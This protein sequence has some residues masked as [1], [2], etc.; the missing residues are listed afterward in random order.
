MKLK[1][2]RI[3]SICLI[4]AVSLEFTSCKQN[5]KA[6]KIS[7]VLKCNFAQEPE[8]IDPALNSSLVGKNVVLNTFEGLTTL[9][10]KGKIEGGAAE[11]WNVSGNGSNYTFFIR[12]D[13]KWSDGKPVTAQDFE[14]AWKRVLNPATNS[15]KAYKLYCIKNAEA[16]N[17]GKAPSGEVGI[18]VIDDYILNVVLEK[19]TPYFL[20]LAASDT[21]VPVRSDIIEKKGANWAS[22]PEMYIGNGPFELQKWDKKKSML[23]I[24]NKNYINSKKIKLGKVEITFENKEEVYSGNFNQGKIDVMYV[25][26]DAEV[27]TLMSKNEA[28]AYNNSGIYYLVFNLKGNSESS[29][30]SKATSN[31]KVRKA[32][33]MAMN[34]NI[35]ANNILN[36]NSKPAVGI[37]SSQVKDSSGGVFRDVFYSAG[38]NLDKAKGLLQEAGYGDGA[39]LPKLKIIYAKSSEN[40]AV[41]EAVKDML[42]RNLNLNLEE[43]AYEMQNLNTELRKRNYDMTLSEIQADYSDAA[44]FLEPWTSGSG[45]NIASYN[46]RAYDKTLD[47][48]EREKSEKARE[49]KIKN[50]EGI[51]MEDMPVV[52][53]V[54]TKSVVCSKKNVHGIY[55]NNYGVI[56]LKNAN[57][58]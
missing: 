41:V 54:E 52:P 53:L 1:F 34:R 22:T 31:S 39:K 45:E 16:Y 5:T 48:G 25:S 30:A 26:P 37:I 44:A 57:L 15:K 55:V 49:D 51:I 19:P 23:L 24:K 21:F 7:Q 2:Y 38:G 11:K 17:K 28:K 27:E 36:G 4:I 9:N 50:A 13:A 6:E 20:T 18:K 47:E 14:Y 29:E 46:N 35:I 56:Y 33:A 10:S 40:S 43:S 58:A 8:T 12:K 3:V 32:I 42:K